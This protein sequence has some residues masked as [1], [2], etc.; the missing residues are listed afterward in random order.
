MQSE[1]I[2]RVVAACLRVKRVA[3]LCLVWLGASE[4]AGGCNVPV[5]RFALERWVS[6][7]YA[8]VVAHDKPLTPTQSELTDRLLGKSTENGGK[9]NLS[10][11]VLDLAATP[12]D[13]T[14]KYLPLENVAL[15]AVFLFFPASFG[16]P[17]LVWQA[18]LTADCVA[19]ITASPLRDEFVA[20]ATT[21]TTAIWILLESGQATEDAAAEQVLR[22]SLAAV[23]QESELP[24]GV[25]HPSG[26]VAGGSTP[27]TTD[28]GYFDPENQLDSGIPL[29]IGF[30]VVRMPAD[31]PREDVL[32]GMLLK[33]V[34]GLLEKRDRPLAFPLFGRGRILAPLAGEEIRHE[35]ITA[36]SRYLCGPCACQVKA[37]NPGVDLLL[38]VD[39]EA[40]LAGAT[41]IPPRTLPPLSGTA[42]I[43]GKAPVAPPLAASA[44][45]QPAATGLPASVLRNGLW[46]SA[47]VVLLVIAAT[48]GILRLRP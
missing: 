46:A 10:V 3:L 19:H 47:T 5:F 43:T 26:A 48:F 30:E 14:V 8:L 35:S 20:Q 15:P 1:P 16:K 9:A 40:K 2:K 45:A 38:D 31:D 23:Q 32:R 25:V 37:Q 24:A 36:I 21:G 7:N 28:N 41:T 27:A 6:D 18:A 17:T 33:V 13:P 29:R 11:Q 22:E 44:A 39:W 4:L 34:P 42:A 12:A